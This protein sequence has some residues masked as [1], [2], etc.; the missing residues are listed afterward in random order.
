MSQ[1]YALFN[2]FAKRRNMSTLNRQQFKPIM[3][4]VIREKYSLGLRNDIISAETDK[5]QCGWKGLRP[6]A[7]SVAA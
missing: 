3:G 4:E 6:V 1:T 7:V 2:Q 5:Q